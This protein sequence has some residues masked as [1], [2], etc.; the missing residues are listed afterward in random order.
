[1]YECHRPVTIHFSLHYSF[2]ERSTVS[3][4]SLREMSC[5]NATRLGCAERGERGIYGS[6]VRPDG[7][8]DPAAG[9]SDAELRHAPRSVG[10]I[11]YVV[12]PLSELALALAARLTVPAPDRL[13]LE[14]LVGHVHVP[15][16]DAPHAPLAVVE[17]ERGVES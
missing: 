6:P 16:T 13:S 14:E 3:Q 8:P 9:A 11:L 15:R 2:Y 12:H 1:M 17:L 4:V 10:G 5:C 7:L